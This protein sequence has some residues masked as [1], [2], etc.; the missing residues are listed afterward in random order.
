MYVQLGRG[1]DYAWS[2]TSAGQ[3]ITDTYAVEL[4]NRTAPRPPRTPPTTCYRG[5]CVPMEKLERTNAWKPTVADSTAAGSYR[6]QVCR[7]KYG[8]VTHRATVGG[9]PVAYTALRSTYRHE[10]DSIIGFQMLN[11]PAYVRDAADLPAGRRAHRLRLQLVLRRLPR[12]RVLQQRPQ[13]GPRRRRRPVPARSRREDAYEWKGCDPATNTADYTPP[14]AAPAVRRPGLLHLL[15]QQAGQ[16][17]RLGR[18][19]QRLG[20]PR[21]PAG[22]PGE[23]ADRRTGGV[24]RAVADPGDGRGRRHRP[25]RRGRAARTAAG[26]QQQAGHRPRADDRGRS[27][28]RPGATDGAQRKE[29][30]AGSQT[31]T[32]ADAVRI[33]DAWWPLLVE[34]EFKPGL[35]GDLYDALRANLAIDESP[36][37]GHGPTGAHAG[38]AFQYGWWSYVDKDCARCSATRWQG[39]LAQPYCGDGDLSA[40]RD[41]LL[42]TLQQAS[43]KTADAGLPRRRQLRGRRPVV[44]GRDHPPHAGRHHPR[45]RSA[46]RTGRPTSRSWSSRRTGRRQAAREG[47]G[48]GDPGAFVRARRVPRRFN[49]RAGC[50]GCPRGGI[51]LGVC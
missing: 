7:T 20:A 42:A 37:A 2:A 22:R 27:S 1:Q 11:D 16:G 41:T 30:A 51:P 21:Q 15:E 43:G 39:P 35:G 24:T 6:M 25:A 18:L 48:A 17:L 47:P 23:G 13:P 3:D 32:H 29:T 8:I 44:R 33:M 5:A 9:K 31:Y 26:P 10:A 28:W 46:G 45:H 19:R 38:S 40:C 34:A 50:P 12:H 49:S 14:A 36:S 4:C